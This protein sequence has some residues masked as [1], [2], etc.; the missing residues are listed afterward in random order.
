MKDYLCGHKIKREEKGIGLIIMVGLLGLFV[1][2]AAVFA[3]NMRLESEVS[4]N[5]YHLVQSGYL[6]QAGISRA[7]AE[8]KYSADGIMADNVDHLSEVWASNYQDTGL[9]DGAGAYEVSVYDCAR[10]ININNSNIINLEQILSNLPGVDAA[11]AQAIIA[12]RNSLP[13]GKFESKIQIMAVSGVDRAL[14][15][16]IKDYITVYGYED[17]NSSY[18]TPV[19]VNTASTE[20]LTALIKDIS[21]GSNTIALT[22]AEAVAAKIEENRPYSHPE[23]WRQFK[24]AL[25]ELVA[26]ASISQAEA[27]LIMNNFNPN[28]E[29]PAIYSCEFSFNSGGYYRLVSLG[30]LST[31][32][33]RVIASRQIIAVVK[34]FDLYNET[35][36]DDFRA[37]WLNDSVIYGDGTEGDAADGELVRVTFMDSYPV[38]SDEDLSSAYTRIPNLLKAGFWDNFE[39]DIDFTNNEWNI[40]DG[41]WHIDAGRFSSAGGMYWPKCDLGSESAQRWLWYN[42]SAR[43]F[44]NDRISVW[45]TRNETGWWGAGY[46]D[47][48]GRLVFKRL[49]S[50]DSSFFHEDLEDG[51]HQPPGVPQ[52]DPGPPPHDGNLHVWVSPNFNDLS[53]EYVL[54]KTLMVVCGNTNHNWC[55]YNGTEVFTDMT[56]GNSHGI[57]RLYGEFHQPEYDNIKIIPENGYFISVPIAAA[58]DV[59]WANVS[60]TVSIPDTASAESETVSFEVS[61]DGGS[62]WQAADA[63]GSLG[64]ISSA[65][66]QYKAVFSSADNSTS[67]LGVKPYYSETA[68]LEDVWLSYMDTSQ[69][70]YWQES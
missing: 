11:T 13:T 61:A 48:V 22:E 57:I 27:D 54:E 18:R 62:S 24:A 58:G 2:I 63:A 34:L 16:S 59:V 1:L 33:G 29:K 31:P 69:I 35:A 44:I 6:A 26:A 66:I 23:G 15:N 17:P 43:A 42:H 9:L 10:R 60:G 70:L 20:V 46:P 28:R 64:G 52:P 5:Y 12:Y 37:V 68:V 38:R 49:S 67:G 50:G 65:S 4:A 19:N 32:G 36:R 14:Y 53:Q 45:Q 41:N 8:L 55:Y 7:I 47:D 21:D 56:G 51:G 25:D 30:Q 40:I 3:V 39:E